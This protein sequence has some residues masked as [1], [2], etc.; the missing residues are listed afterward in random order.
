MTRDR[1]KTGKSERKG[2]GSSKRK[3]NG[4]DAG[5]R[6]GRFQGTARLND[7][8]K[9]ACHENGMQPIATA[10]SNE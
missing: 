5:R 2:V 6:D 3:E 9:A 4:L 10:T 1:R 8:A 7:K